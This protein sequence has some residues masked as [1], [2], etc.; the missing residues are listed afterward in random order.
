MSPRRTILYLFVAGCLH[1]HTTSA[2]ALP[3]PVTRIPAVTADSCPVSY[4]TTIFFLP[5][6]TTLTKP[7]KALLREAAA[8]A[9]AC[10]SCKIR[11]IASE[12]VSC[13]PANRKEEKRSQFGWDRAMHIGDFLFNTLHVLSDRIIVSF[14]ENDT[15]NKVIL[16]CVDQSEWPGSVPG[17]HPSQHNHDTITVYFDVSRSSLSCE[18]ISI[19]DAYFRNSAHIKPQ[20]T[21]A[22]YCD[23]TGAEAYNNHLSLD[24]ARSVN[25]YLHQHWL[26]STAR[27]SLSAYGTRFPVDD[28]NTG[29]GRARNRRVTIIINSG[30]SPIPIADSR[31]IYKAITDTATRA[32]TTIILKDVVFYGGRRIPLPISFIALD[33]LVK[34][35]QENA[36][37]HI[38]I[39]GHVC[40]TPDST[41]GLD[42]ETGQSNLSTQRAKMVFDY[43]IKHGIPEH[44]VTYIG[45]GG[46]GKLYPEELNAAQQEANRRVGIRIISK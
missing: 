1:L 36:N 16:E 20:L 29:S 25:D 5:D 6:R 18:G 15:S 35:M 12:Q 27:I 33:D 32:G 11:L 24:R 2:S 19:I 41:D 13:F 26:D 46:S 3:H 44:R 40:C 37:L 31:S 43:L 17:P 28:N 23:N 30:S 4:L 42:E 14:S 9:L 38:R 21:I 34:A 39:E 45:L 22:G 7:A 10:D 8:T